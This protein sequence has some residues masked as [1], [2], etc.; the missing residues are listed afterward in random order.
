MGLME[1]AKGSRKAD[2][3]VVKAFSR[4]IEEDVDIRRAYGI[5]KGYA[6]TEVGNKQCQTIVR[7]LSDY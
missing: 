7:K 1:H 5:C 4:M 3:S 6:H 2:E